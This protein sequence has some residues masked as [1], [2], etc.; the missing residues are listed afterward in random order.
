MGKRPANE[1][2]RGANMQ[3]FTKREHWRQYLRDFRCPDCGSTDGVRSRRRTF[4]ER[5]LL[6]VLTL[7][8]VRCGDCFRRFYLPLSVQV[9]DRSEPARKASEVQMRPT[10]QPGNRVA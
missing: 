8:P 3:E 6:P 9:R 5:Y 10:S 2:P 1:S 4:L 7:Q